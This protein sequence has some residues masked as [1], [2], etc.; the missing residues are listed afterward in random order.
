MGFG[1]CFLFSLFSAVAPRC[2]SPNVPSVCVLLSASPLKSPLAQVRT[3]PHV[4]VWCS[5]VSGF[6]FKVGWGSEAVRSCLCA[7]GFGVGSG[8]GFFGFWK[9]WGSEAVRLVLPVRPFPLLCS[10]RL[11][12]VRNTSSPGALR[13]QGG[14]PRRFGAPRRRGPSVQGLGVQGFFGLGRRVGAQRQPGRECASA[15]ARVSA[16]GWGF[17]GCVV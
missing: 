5:E 10:P 16:E 1:V 3:M 6:L 12:Q 2:V 15:G 13:F 8:P 11:A 14:L 17:R 7:Q 4:F 9:A